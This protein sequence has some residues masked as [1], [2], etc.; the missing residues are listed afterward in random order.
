MTVAIWL[1]FGV[2]ARPGAPGIQGEDHP[3][4]YFLPGA[5]V[6]ETTD[7]LMEL[8]KVDRP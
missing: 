4:K 8:C 5:N 6:K 1:S 7:A 3:D 2:A